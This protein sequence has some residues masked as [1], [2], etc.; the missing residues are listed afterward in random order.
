MSITGTVMLDP[1][2]ADQ[3]ASKS[4]VPALEQTNLLDQ[5]LKE[6]NEMSAVER[7][8]QK[9]E[10]EKGRLQEPYYKDLIPIRKPS[11]GEQYAFEVEL[12]KCTGCKACVVA[13][14]SLNGLHENESWRDIGSIRGISNGVVEQ[15][16]VTS[17]CHHS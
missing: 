14:H 5:I 4:S 11:T 15:Q 12:D 8:S 1:K 13:C 7:F 10:S 9:H 2:N 16:T 6:Q 3:S 17:A